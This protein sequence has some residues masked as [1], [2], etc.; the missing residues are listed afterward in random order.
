MPARSPSTTIGLRRFEG[1]NILIDSTYLGPSYLRRSQNWVPG[2]TFRLEKRWGTADYGGGDL[3]IGVT[4]VHVLRSAE[5]G[6]DNLFFAVAANAGVDTIYV[7]VAN[8]AW[9]PVSGSATFASVGTRYDIEV[10]NGFAYVGNGIDPIKRIDLMTLT[11]VD[12]L[13]IAPFTDGSAA[14]TLVADSGSQILTGTYSYC[15]CIFDGL[16]KIWVE[17]SQTREVT[18]RSA[19]D[20]AI[21]F[22][23]PTGMVSPIVPGVITAHLFVSPVDYPIE[24]AHDQTTVGLDSGTTVLRTV[25]AD[26]PPVPLRGPARVGSIMRAYYGRLVIAGDE[27]TPEAVWCTST[28]APG[29]EQAIFDAG[30]FWPHNGRLPRAPEPVTGIGLVGPGERESSVQSPLVVMTLTRTYLWYG[31]IL[32]DPSA[33][34]VL[35]SRRAGCISANSVVETPYG[36]LYCGL[37]SVYMVPSG[38]AVPVD[39]GWP[40]RPAI[41]AIPFGVRHKVTAL[42]HKGFYK[43][44]IVPPG[45]ST[46][47]QQ[48]WL[49]LRRGPTTIPSWWGPHLGVAPSAWATTPYD[50]AQP[51][52]G[53]HAID[54]TNV[55]ERIYQP[56]SYHENHGAT[57]IISVLTTGD[58]DGGT[59]FDE[60]IITMVRGIGFPARTTTVSVSMTLDGGLATP[61]PPLIFEGQDG[62]VWNVSEWNLASWGQVAF[63]LADAYAP[64]QRPRARVI[65]LQLTHAEPIGIALREL[66]IS[67]MGPDIIGRKTKSKPRSVT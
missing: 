47:I 40:I 37:E 55:I 18:K 41:Q 26:G 27:G 28:L 43:L 7:S 42:Y 25:I 15:W 13:A 14:A 62:A 32:D 50:T 16:N 56:N 5:A 46:P 24:F 10:V 20:E 49:D 21:S 2:E 45:S 59:P 8:A 22:P 9:T 4:Q 23:F 53:I 11:A 12:L 1:T 38:G 35:A 63:T 58:L 65:T 60:K 48:W 51:D 6:G 44:A 33:Q 52:L 19:A 39:V 36:L 30:V 66:E 31:D 61:Y 57:K 17:R 3:P 64:P 29:N 67:Y 54:G 34:W